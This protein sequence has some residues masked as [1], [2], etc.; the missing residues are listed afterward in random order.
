MSSPSGLDYQLLSSQMRAG[1]CLLTAEAKQE[2]LPTL[3]T[4]FQAH[5]T[6]RA[7]NQGSK[8]LTEQYTSLLHDNYGLSW[9]DIGLV[10]VG[11]RVYDLALEIVTKHFAREA[12]A[13][14][15]ETILYCIPIQRYT[16][17]QH[18]LIVPAIQQMD[19]FAGNR[20]RLYGHAISLIHCQAHRNN[21][22][23]V[24]AKL[25]ESRLIDPAQKHGYCCPQVVRLN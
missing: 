5:L 16:D 11:K 15:R 1:D 3:K 10:V 6:L 19:S 18:E 2:H 14:S 20:T 7:I 25:A 13:S 9:Q 4:A 8:E 22:P 21:Q 24:I 23:E 17:G 12:D